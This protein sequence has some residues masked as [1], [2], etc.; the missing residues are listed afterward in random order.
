MERQAP[1]SLMKSGAQK[2]KEK[3]KH[4]LVE[5]AKD[6]KQQKLSFAGPKVQVDQSTPVSELHAFPIK[7]QIIRN[8]TL[9]SP[10]N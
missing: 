5:A 10:K 6:P 8:S 7:K 1:K 4:E 2:R 3:R 9:R